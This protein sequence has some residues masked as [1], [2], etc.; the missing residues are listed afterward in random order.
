MTTDLTVANTILEQLGGRR[1]VAFTG[2]RN[3]V[4]SG[5]T[6]TFSL[7]SGSTKDGSNRVKVTL[8][9]LDLYTVET[10]SV[11]GTSFKAKSHMDGVYNDMLAKVFTSLTG[12]VTRF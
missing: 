8:T 3:F 9:P 1:F 12:L 5:D 6:L 4:G 10:F 11:R 7:P 2:A